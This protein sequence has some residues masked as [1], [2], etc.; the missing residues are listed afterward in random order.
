MEKLNKKG[1]VEL[2]IYEILGVKIFRFLVFKLEK[3]IHHKDKM[4]NINYHVKRINV[5]EF[6]SFKKY[7]YYNGFIHV[8]NLIFLFVILLLSLNF[9]NPIFL[10]ILILEF[11]KNTY[12][13]ML[14]RY[15]YIRINQSIQRKKEFISR[16]N[17]KRNENILKEEVLTSNLN[18]PVIDAQL[19]Q[20]EK[21][22]QGQEDV[23]ITEKYRDALELLKKYLE[24]YSKNPSNDPSP[25][26]HSTQ[27]TV[28]NTIENDYN[29]HEIN[30]KR[31]RRL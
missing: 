25:L 23:V 9:T 7:L 21:F 16:K 11:I 8:R 12:C 28:A 22:F 3:I 2:K 19:E 24:E 17:Q 30:P 31:E 10:V 20:L 26:S 4:Q 27:N 1:N 14:Q 29:N 18:N 15:N 5:D 13:V 6:E